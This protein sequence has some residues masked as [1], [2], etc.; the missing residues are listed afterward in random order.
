MQDSA[1]GK[2]CD[3]IGWGWTIA[4]SLKYRMNKDKWKDINVSRGLQF[5]SKIK[6]SI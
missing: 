2:V 6:L 3:L 5:N 4:T 1:S